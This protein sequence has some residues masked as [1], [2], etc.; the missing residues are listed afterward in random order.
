MKPLREEHLSSLCPSPHIWK[1]RQRPEG[2]VRYERKGGRTRT[3][4]CGAGVDALTKGKAL[5]SSRSLASLSILGDSILARRRAISYPITPQKREARKS[6]ANEHAHN[7]TK[8]QSS[9]FRSSAPN[10]LSLRS[11]LPPLVMLVMSVREQGG[12]RRHRFH[13]FLLIC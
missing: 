3:C 12:R 8:A 4:A 6:S 9:S 2:V 7:R 1:G 13:F 10:L 5:F 11:S